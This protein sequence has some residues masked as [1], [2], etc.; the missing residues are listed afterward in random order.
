MLTGSLRVPSSPSIAPSRRGFLL[1]SVLIGGSLTVGFRPAEASDALPQAQAPF[2]H[3]SVN[4][5][6]AYLTIAP[7]STVT[8]HV[9]HMDMGQGIYHGAATLV[10]EELEA[11]WAQMRADGAWGNIKLYGNLAWGGAMQGTGGSTGIAS[12]FDRYRQA[13]AAARHIL[14][15]AASSAWK[16]P[17][18]EITVEAGVL[19]HPSGRRAGSARW[20]RT[21]APSR[22]RRRC[23]SRT[24][25]AG[26]SSATRTCRAS[27]AARSRPAARPSRST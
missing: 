15:A 26:G 10:A 24:R 9:A 6:N 13:G 1:G 2:A 5:L 22:S 7:D 20:S 21:P 17:K 25:R 11:D 14:L 27:T 3:T 19:S 23:A 8:V 16:V 18:A 4:P 12:S